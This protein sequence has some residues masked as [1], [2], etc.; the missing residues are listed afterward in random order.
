[1]TQ[2]SISPE[3]LAQ[4]FHIAPLDIRSADE[5]AGDLGFIPGSL[6]LHLPP[7]GPLHTLDDLG[8]LLQ[9]AEAVAL[10]CLSGRRAL[11]LQRRL[12]TLDGKPV[13]VLDGGMLAWTQRGL[14]VAGIPD[15]DAS[16]HLPIPTPQSLFRALLAC[17]SASATEAILDH[18]GDPE[19]LEARALLQHAF[20]TAGVDP[21][22]PDPRHVP[23]LL[24]RLAFYS[25]TLGAPLDRIR[26]NIDNVIINIHA[27]K[28]A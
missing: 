26:D 19:L 7:D 10:V 13:L 1:M 14:P 16:P 20:I 6:H 9:H 18:D 22:Q 4:A 5:R 12:P 23:L 15:P 17:F 24:D 11:E 3:A 27:W 21:E 25:R 8:G 28:P 2:P